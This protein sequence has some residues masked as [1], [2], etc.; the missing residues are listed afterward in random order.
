MTFSKPG[1]K[2]HFL[3]PEEW[4]NIL[5][6]KLIF[7]QTAAFKKKKKKTS[8]DFYLGSLYVNLYLARGQE[9]LAAS[10]RRGIFLFRDV[11]Y[12]LHSR[13]SITRLFM[14]CVA[15][16][17]HGNPCRCIRRTNVS[18]RRIFPDFSSST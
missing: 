1:N 2:T 17:C 3:A 12:H 13:L 16:K 7:H 11:I 8:T 10:L 9:R 6:I 18:F 5:V 14:C 15:V 4:K